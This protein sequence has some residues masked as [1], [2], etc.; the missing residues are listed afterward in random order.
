MSSFYVNSSE[1]TVFPAVGRTY[2]NDTAA[3]LMTEKNASQI[4]RSLYK[5]HNF[6]IAGSLNKTSGNI[7]IVLGGYYFNIV[8]SNVIKNNST[9]YAAIYTVDGN[10]VFKYQY[11]Q[12]IAD[13][14]KSDL[15]DSSN[16]QFQ[17]LGLYTTE[18]EI[19]STAT[20]TLKILDNNI[21]P[22][23]SYLHYNPDE[24]VDESTGKAITDTINTGTINNTT[25]NTT[26][27]KAQYIYPDD[28]NASYIG[29]ISPDKHFDLVNATTLNSTN[30]YT[31]NIYIDNIGKKTAD[32]I[33]VATGLSLASGKK[34]AGQLNNSI[35]F[36]ASNSGDSSGTIF[37]NT[38]NKTISANTI[39]AVS[40][41]LTSAKGDMIYASSANNPTRLAI[42]T[43]GK[44]LRANSSNL[45]E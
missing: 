29:S 37:N 22:P 44:L 21:V 9:L 41:K 42:G 38:A 25:I 1:I 17:G 39:G 7:Q 16:L 2:T 32:P 35:T 12:N 33:T 30:T 15:D 36:D 6:V 19:P 10:N 11:L 23:T 24:I 26:T 13:N 18:G 8:G 45:P 40:K 5:R 43:V 4:T 3:H 31:T 14:T 27:I 34:Y 20:Y 28:N